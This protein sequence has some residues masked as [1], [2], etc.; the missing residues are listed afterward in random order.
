MTRAEKNRA[1][2]RLHEAVK[3]GKVKRQTC[4]DCTSCLVEAHHH[5]GYEGESA[6]D[7]TWLCRAHHLAAHGHK[8]RPAWEGRVREYMAET[9]PIRRGDQH[10]WYFS[11]NSNPTR[12]LQIIEVVWTMLRTDEERALAA[13]TFARLTAPEPPALS[14]RVA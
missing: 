5:N 8:P 1:R 6:L 7:V 12:L 3:A 2:N 10:S 9:R 4:A 14:L 13:E 11:A